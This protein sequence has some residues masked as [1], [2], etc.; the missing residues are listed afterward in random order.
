MEDKI[1]KKKYL[2]YIDIVILAIVIFFVASI[3]INKLIVKNEMKNADHAIISNKNVHMYSSAK[4]GKKF[5]ALEMG[6]NAYILKTVEDKNGAE[7]KKI[8]VGDKVGYV[9]SENISKYNPQ[10]KK[11]D[12]MIDV[13]KFNMQNTFNNVGEFKAFVINNNIKFVY[14]R[15]GGRGYGKAGN[16]YT[17][18]KADDYAQACEFLNIPFGYYFL[19]EAIT[20]E[21]VNQEVDFIN[22]YLD[23]HRYSNNI[24]PVAIDVEKHAETGRADKIWDIRYKYVDE[25]IKKIESNGRRALLYSNAN[26]ANKYLYNVDSAMWLAYY[27]EVT[28]IPDYWYSDT[29]GDGALN[30]VLISKLVGWQFTENGVKD[31]MD[32]KIDISI[33]YS[34]YFIE[35]DTTDIKNDMKESNEKVFGPINNMINTILQNKGT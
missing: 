16:F 34:K 26:I 28:S 4:E 6:A 22:E 17:D 21:E 5:D 10:Y 11:K 8:K 30:K 23:K 18:P 29:K 3:G 13:S 2:L 19:D 31:T 33:V 12:I 1:N 24:L 35:D 25:L 15:A 14:I 27:P 7:W 9:K 32:K 20:T